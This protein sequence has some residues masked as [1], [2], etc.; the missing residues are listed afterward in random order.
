MKATWERRILGKMHKRV[1]YRG[2]SCRHARGGSSVMDA[3]DEP[4]PQPA[5][6]PAFMYNPL[7]SARVIPPSQLAIPSKVGNSI[8]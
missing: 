1:T 5:A 7:V 3:V 2:L 6:S 4:P 8:M